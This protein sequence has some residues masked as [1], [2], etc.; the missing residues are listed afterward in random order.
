MTTPSATRPILLI[1]DDEPDVRQLVRDVAEPMGWT[2]TEAS[3]GRELMDRYAAVVPDAILLDIIM[4]DMDGI[5][6][7]NWLAEQ[8]T[9][10]RIAV[11][12]GYSATYTEV[13]SALGTS[14][15]L[16]IAHNLHK[17]FSI[18]DLRQAL[19]IVSG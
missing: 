18:S 3:S 5:E 8:R 14:Q 17:P 9:S 6:V 2:V 4:P 15:G 11:M 12:T 19:A 16:N 7:L 13:A 1:V 10:A